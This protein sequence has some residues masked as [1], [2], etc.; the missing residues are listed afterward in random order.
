[1]I[2]SMKSSLGMRP[3]LFLSIF[4][5]KSVSRDFLWFMNFK[6][7]RQKSNAIK[8]QN[9][10]IQLFYLFIY[11]NI[12]VL[13]SST[14]PMRSS[15][16][17]RLLSNSSDV[18]ADDADVPKPLATRNAIYPTAVDNANCVTRALPLCYR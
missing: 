3:S 18:P 8:T 14:D 15:L 12:H 6:N 4:L 5:N 9:R 11:F 2:P 16:L 7:F 13:V 17:S 10:N 1:M